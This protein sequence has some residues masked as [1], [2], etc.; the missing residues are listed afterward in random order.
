MAGNPQTVIEKTFT[1]SLATPLGNLP[2][3]S[4]KVPDLPMRLSELVP[5]MQA[6][7]DKIVEQACT[8]ATGNGE[9]V[10]CSKGCSACCRQVVPVSIPEALFLT[11]R[12]E[13]ME[14]AEGTVATRRLADAMT[15]CRRDGLLDALLSASSDQAAIG[16]AQEYFNRG[17]VCPFLEEGAC[18]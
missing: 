11:E 15:T 7:C 2:P 9:A 12:M 6:I 8:S 13:A 1:F 10:T 17:I 4:V 3:L 18:S 5:L 14:P 16:A